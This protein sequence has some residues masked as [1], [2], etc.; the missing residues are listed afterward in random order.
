[1][2]TLPYVYK[3]LSL[4]SICALVLCFI[5]AGQ[6]LAQGC[7]PPPPQCT[8]NPK[9]GKI[10]CTKVCQ[11]TPQPTSRPTAQGTNPPPN[12]PPPRGTPPP[13]DRAPTTTPAPGSTATPGA[14]TPWPSGTPGGGTPTASPTPTIW[15]YFT[16]CYANGTSGPPGMSSA[17]WNNL[18]NAAE[19]AGY[20]GVQVGIYYIYDQAGNITTTWF[21][22][23][24]FCLLLPPPTPTPTPIVYNPPCHAQI[25]V[26]SSGLTITC[27]GYHN[28]ISVSSAPPCNEVNRNPA[29]RGLVAVENSFFVYP[30]AGT[31][32]HGVGAETWSDTCWTLNPLPEA[33]D[34]RPGRT[35]VNYQ[36]GLRWRLL[37]NLPPQWDFDERAWNAGRSGTKDSGWSVKHTYET[38][39]FGKPANGPNFNMPGLFDLPAYQVKVETYW[40]AEWAE[41]W[42]HWHE[43]CVNEIVDPITGDVICKRYEYSWHEHFNGWNQLD[44]RRYG[45]PTYY[46]V[47]KSVSSPDV[48]ILPT[49]ICVLTIPVPDH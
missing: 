22:V 33:K 4:A 36:I 5:M 24:A 11:A 23:E 18:E 6:T 48:R 40:V 15:K 45:N 38:S 9:T 7:T 46:F 2:R 41:R 20:G 12:T 21:V 34:Y 3:R 44:L 35:E 26:D 10:T 30:G 19:N 13:T 31:N 16:K 43:D 17:E 1:M 32:A 37:R 47:N 25:I 28:E 29:P 14:G 39:S 49:N 42:L 27:D 8:F